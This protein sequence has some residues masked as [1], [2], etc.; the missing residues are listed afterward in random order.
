MKLKDVTFQTVDKA[1]WSEYFHDLLEVEVGL[2]FGDAIG[3]VG[4]HP[5]KFTVLDPTP[6]R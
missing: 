3:C 4:E 5:F 1:E 2:V 6:I